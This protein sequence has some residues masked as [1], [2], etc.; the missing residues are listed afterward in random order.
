MNKHITF[1]LL[2]A[3]ATSH[4]MAQSTLAAPQW[5]GL[6][7]ASLAVTSG[8]SSTQALLVN[9]DI[10]RATADDK[11]TIVGFINEG[12]SKKAGV[13]STT[14]G[15][16]GVAGQYDRNL[17]ADVYGFGKLGVDHDRVIDLSLRSQ[18]AAGLGYHLIRTPADTFDVFG[19]VAYTS[20]SYKTPQTIAGTTDTRF[21]STG[22][23]LGEEST[24]QLN[25]A[26]F[27]KQRLEYY[28]GMTGNQNQMVKFNAGLSVSMSRSLALTV[29][30]VDT[31]N[32]KVAAGVK[33]NDLS[34][35]TGV[36][37]KIG[38]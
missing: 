35:F 27:F 2:A 29:G 14:A 37:Y 3:L 28:P 8:N 36:S 11:V 1:T 33:K 15:K 18:V 13:S 20:S 25:D 10:A 5:R 31:Y 21:N 12:K 22:L 23:L 26:V 4:A 38:Q 19:G 24:H 6:A 32:S 16:W 30:V 34:V 17:T 9:A 7:G